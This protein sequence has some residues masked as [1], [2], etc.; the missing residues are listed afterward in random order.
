MASRRRR[1]IDLWSDAL[2]ANTND[3]DTE[4]SLRAQLYSFGASPILELHS[5]L[6]NGRPENFDQLGTYLPVAIMDDGLERWLL[7][8]VR[9]GTLTSGEAGFHGRLRDFPNDCGNGHFELT[10]NISG[11]ELDY[12]PP[13]QAP[14]ARAI[15][16][17]ERAELLGWPPIRDVDGSI[18]FLDRKLTIEV[19]KGA[20]RN[21]RLTS[22]SASIENLWR[23]KS[24]R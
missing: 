9:A 8:S 15:T 11:G 14:E 6:D 7:G 19:D 20:L 13:R 4:T 22:G 2:T 21:T 5:R 18:R 23:P 1:R 16:D 12:L 24:C 17:A 3:I 10:L